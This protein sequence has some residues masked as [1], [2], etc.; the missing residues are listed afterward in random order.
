MFLDLGVACGV[1]VGEWAGGVIYET[2]YMK[3][4]L[5]PVY[6]EEKKIGDVPAFEGRAL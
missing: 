6:T 1:C 4:K 2:V 5:L 3:M